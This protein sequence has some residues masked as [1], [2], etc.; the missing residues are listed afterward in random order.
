MKRH[1]IF[2]GDGLPAAGQAQ[3]RG[4]EIIAVRAKTLIDNPRQSPSS[5]TK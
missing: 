4:P 3:P 5:S 2:A 1:L